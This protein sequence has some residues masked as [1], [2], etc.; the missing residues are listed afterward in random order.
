M[1]G[2]N[3]PGQATSALSC[4][5]NE[6]TLWIAPFSVAECSLVCHDVKPSHRRP[7]VPFA[8]GLPGT[9]WISYNSRRSSYF[10]S[11]LCNSV[12]PCRRRWS[13]FPAKLQSPLRERLAPLLAGATARAAF[14]AAL[15]VSNPEM[16]TVIELRRA[17]SAEDDLAVKVEALFASAASAVASASGVRRA[18]SLGRGSAAGAAA[19]GP[20]WLPGVCGMYF[21]REGD[22]L[23]VIRQ[24]EMG[25]RLVVIVGGP[26]Q[27]RGTACHVLWVVP[28]P[29]YISCVVFYLDDMFHG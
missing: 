10:L 9:G 1:H 6:K 21:G 29:G 19:A 23:S 18:A 16:V 2:T 26:G 4:A 27:A 8:T 5:R 22:R 3:L 28:A 14:E 11:F 17:F 13:H 15:H 25:K 24:L 12:L 7:D 20:C